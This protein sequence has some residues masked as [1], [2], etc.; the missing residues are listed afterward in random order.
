MK[1]KP[2]EARKRENLA[3]AFV[4]SAAAIEISQGFRKRRLK[5]LDDAIV[6]YFF[7]ERSRV[8]AQAFY[9]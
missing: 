5:S 6:F 4:I 3:R 9:K 1:N 2:S 7:G 8:P